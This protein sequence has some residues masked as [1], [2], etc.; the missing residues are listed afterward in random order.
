MTKMGVK[1]AAKRVVKRCRLASQK[2]HFNK[3]NLPTTIKENWDDKMSFKQNFASFGLNTDVNV[4]FRH[5][6][7]GRSVMKTAQNSIYKAKY[8]N[9]M[10]LSDDEDD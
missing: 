8:G 10:N 3:N 6:K 7:A 1:R 5:S 4:K 2:K 9:D